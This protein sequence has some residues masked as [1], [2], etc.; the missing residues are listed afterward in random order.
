M[1]PIYAHAKHPGDSSYG[2]Q[3]PFRHLP[4]VLVFIK[5]AFSPGTSFTVFGEHK[6]H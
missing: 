5:A 1:Q 6:M 3:H 2:L 4:A